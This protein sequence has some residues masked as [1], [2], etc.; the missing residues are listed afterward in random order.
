M[1]E[2]A[3]T[4]T[5]NCVVFF[6]FLSSSA[7]T[8]E[9][10]LF[11][12]TLTPTSH[13]RRHSKSDICTHT[14]HF[15]VFLF[16]FCLLLCYR[17][18]ASSSSLRCFAYLLFCGRSDDTD[19]RGCSHE[20]INIF[21]IMSSSFWC[22]TLLWKRFGTRRKKKTSDFNAAWHASRRSDVEVRWSVPSVRKLNKQIVVCF[23]CLLP[24]RLNCFLFFRRNLLMLL[25]FFFFCNPTST[26][27]THPRY[28]EKRAP[29]SCVIFTLCCSAQFSWSPPPVYTA[30]S[31]WHNVSFN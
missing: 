16:C 1:H 20:I 13:R 21:L 17:S 12:S 14:A 30:H 28:P 2:H 8:T 29:R 31:A 3:R 19:A 25:F 18:L 11:C 4:A 24:L 9:E 6:C 27:K 10:I 15:G 22:S 7:L 26:L 23:F 5:P